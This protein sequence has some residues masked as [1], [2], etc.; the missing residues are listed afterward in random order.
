[1]KKSS[2]KKILIVEDELPL[3]SS[4]KDKFKA[5]G[6]DVV[7]AADGQKGFEVAKIEKPDLILVDILLP[8]LDGIS[9]AKKIN[10]LG[11][12]TKMIFLTN[13]SDSKHISDAVAAEVTD[14]LVKADWS[15]NDVVNKVK[16]KLGLK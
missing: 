5:A 8:K 7:V 14:Y 13:L 11:L 9:M 10:K 16:Q 12:G 15:I 1:M 3:S 2:S 6:F 4:L